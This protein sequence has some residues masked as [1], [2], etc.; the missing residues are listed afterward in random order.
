MADGD[1]II[2]DKINWSPD[3]PEWATEAT[4]AKILEKLGGQLDIVKKTATKTT[5]NLKDNTKAQKDTTTMLEKGFKSMKEAARNQTSAFNKFSAQ[6]LIPK[7]PFKAFNNG[8]QKVAGKLGIFGA[9]LGAVGFVIGGIIGRM[10]AF[11]DQFRQLF[12]VGFRFEKGSIGL[13]Q[14]AVRAEMSLDQY[15]EILGRYSTTIGVLGTR[16]FSDL[17]VQMRETLME[18]GLLGMNLSE[19]TEY[20]ADYLDQRR[21]LGILEETDRA[22]L[23][24][25]TE[26]YLKNISAMSTLLNVSRDQISQIVKSSVTV[27]AFTNAL[28]KAPQELREQM[29]AT[30]QVV[31]AGF[32]ALGNDYGNALANAFTTAVGRGGLYFTEVG[33]ELL[34]ISQPLYHAMSELANTVGPQEAGAKFS[35]MLDIMANVSDAERQRLMILERSNTQYAQGARNMITL[36]N[37]A[38]QLEEEQI[39]AIRNMEKMREAQRP[40]DTTRAFTN[41]EIAMQKLRVV[42]D[43]FFTTL[44]G[45]NR[46]L[47]LFE[48]IMIKLSKAVVK[49]ADWILERAEKIGDAIANVVTRLMDWIKGFEGMGLGASIARALSGVFGLMSDMIVGA[50]VKG[51]KMALPG[52]GAAKRAE[53]QRQI[54]NQDIQRLSGGG[55][56][57]DPNNTTFNKEWLKRWSGPNATRFD[58]DND[59]V[60]GIANELPPTLAKTF[61]SMFP[62]GDVDTSAIETMQSREGVFATILEEVTKS[63]NKDLIEALNKLLLSQAVLVSNTAK[64]TLDDELGVKTTTMSGTDIAN[65]LAGKQDDNAVLTGT[66]TPAEITEAK[67]KI[68]RQYLPMA[69][70]GDPNQDATGNY[71][72][73]MIAELKILNGKQEK[74]IKELESANAKL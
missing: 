44:F 20:T 48:R 43:K 50:I 4:Q 23:A 32:A 39:A 29:L 8:I 56:N 55:L 41:L 1:R 24:Q 72:E 67:L 17:N 51:M 61:A 3:L 19:L 49:F 12:A 2:V 11:S 71:Y 15:S 47:N 70:K 28:N 25:Q 9:A 68:M 10:K 40:D 18:V 59:I 5:T 74:Q 14:A 53:S 35:A 62:D 13:A 69:G 27:A 38:Q 65:N 33:R 52:G 34:A 64:A 36:I 6:K 30:A 7:T 58:F 21:L 66:K 42:Y 63:G 57:I 54:A 31:T 45:N 22:A 37:Q 60:S 26:T 46:I 16:A 73:Q